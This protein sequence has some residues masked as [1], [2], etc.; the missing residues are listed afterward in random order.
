MWKKEKFLDNPYHFWY[1]FCML[2]NPK[3]KILKVYFFKNPSGTEPVRDWL[4]LR[5]H[6]D[7]KA[8]GEDIK[9]VEFLWPVGYPQVVLSRQNRI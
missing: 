2:E 3:E 6:E 4:K 1:Y 9:A 5:T 7:K 8:I